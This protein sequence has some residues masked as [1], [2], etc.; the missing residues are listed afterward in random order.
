MNLFPNRIVDSVNGLVGRV[1]IA[2]L[3]SVTLIG[4]RLSF[5]DQDG[6][7]LDGVTIS[8]NNVEGLGDQL[9][10][11]KTSVRTIEVPKYKLVTYDQ[12]GV[13][14]Y[15]NL[16]GFTKGKQ[17]T[18]IFNVVDF[19]KPEVISLS[20]EDKSLQEESLVVGFELN[21]ERLVFDDLTTNLDTITT[22]F[23]IN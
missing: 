16:T 10:E 7:E 23:H 14:E 6:N 17:E 20:P 19:L 11:L 21:I 2:V 15:L 1:K 13:V 22:K 18:I 8:T 12:E 4:S 3:R 5:F 9:G